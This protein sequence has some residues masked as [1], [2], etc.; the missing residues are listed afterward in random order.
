VFRGPR[1]PVHMIAEFLAQ[2]ATPKEL[3]ERYPRLTAEMIRLAPIYAAAYQ[4]R[5]KGQLDAQAICGQTNH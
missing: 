5:G 4:L 2:G 3:R 1:V